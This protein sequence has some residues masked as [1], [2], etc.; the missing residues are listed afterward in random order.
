LKKDQR[1]HQKSKRTLDGKIPEEIYAEVLKRDGNKCVVCG[2]PRMIECHHIKAKSLGGKGID[3]SNLAMMCKEC[4]YNKLHARG[5]YTTI[6]K[7]YLYMIRIG[8]RKY[9]EV[10]ELFEYKRSKL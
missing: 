9:V 6:K 5:D 1:K 2:N 10:L 3:P 7:L 4:H 8:Y